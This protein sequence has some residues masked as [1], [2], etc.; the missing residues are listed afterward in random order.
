MFI[1][2]LIP[3]LFME[4]YISLDMLEKIGAL[5]ATLWTLATMFIGA[6]LLKN[7][8]YAIMGNMQ[9]LQQ[10]KLDIRKFQ[11]ATTFYMLGAILLIVPGVLSDILGTFSLF[12]TTYL[13]FIA[14]I[15][16]EEP[17]THM[18]SKGENDVIDVE[19][20]ND[21]PDRY[22]RIER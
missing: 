14:K 8:P 18:K 6:G 7:S 21:N 19:I 20:V 3:Y 22:D 2:V 1:V 17:K 13:Q 4:L 15:T 5:W 12:Y 11:D 10:G 9:S 16:P